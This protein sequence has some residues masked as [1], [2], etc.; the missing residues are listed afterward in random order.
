MS[1]SN[2]KC[3]PP[4]FGTHF[5]T[6]TLSL[7]TP[8]TI[9]FIALSIAFVRPFR[10]SIIKFIGT[11]TI[12]SREFQ[13]SEKIFLIPFQA[14]FHAV[15]KTPAIKITTLLRVVTKPFI[16]S[17]IRFIGTFTIFLREFQTPPP[18]KFHKISIDKTEYI[19]YN[20]DSGCIS[21]L[22]E[23][24]IKSELLLALIKTFTSERFAALSAIVT[25]GAAQLAPVC[26]KEYLWKISNFMKLIQNISAI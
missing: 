1:R 24:L 19:G 22:N 14:F 17:M 12:F 9:Q 20:I 13:I 6:S 10:R 25:A 18:S 7:F 8:S 11:F 15:L 26:F 4:Y 23:K 5:G 16:R 2:P 21:A 3:L